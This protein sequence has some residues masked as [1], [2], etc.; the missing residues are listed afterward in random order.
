M[1]D[2]RTGTAGTADEV[3]AAE[4]A[5]DLIAT[6]GREDL[7]VVDRIGLLR[8]ALLSPPLARIPERSVTQEIHDARLTAG[9][10][11]AAIEL[12]DRAIARGQTEATLARGARRMLSPVECLVLAWRRGGHVEYER[13]RQAQRARGVIVW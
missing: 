6:S 9:W 12:Y 11:R 3:V 8:A 4:V 2:D 10:V 7:P 5:F 13:V 1:G